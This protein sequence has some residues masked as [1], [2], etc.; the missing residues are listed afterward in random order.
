MG[1]ATGNI[2]QKPITVKLNKEQI[3]VLDRIV[4]NGEF[5][6]RS[7]ALRELVL[8]ALQAGVV[9]M[10]TGKGWRGMYTYGVEI[11]KL[12][13]KMDAVA[14]NSKNLRDV[15]GQVTLDLEGIPKII[16]SL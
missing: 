14:K 4:E 16:P 13:K 11:K 15:D 6:G 10:N 9:A 3:L 12:S 1:K 2:S 5:N 7:H 8:P